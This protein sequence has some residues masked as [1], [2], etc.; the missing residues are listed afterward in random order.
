MADATTLERPNAVSLSESAARQVARMLAKEPE[1]AGLMLRLSVTG[2]GCSGFQYNFAFDDEVRSD[3]R[4]F[5][6]DGVKLV[7]DET[8]LDLLAGSEVDYVEE[9]IGASFQVK[10]PKAASSCG[11]GTSFAL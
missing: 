5:E 6:R 1:G 10:N 7:V 11:C 8:S 4:V 2:G 9:L 3:D